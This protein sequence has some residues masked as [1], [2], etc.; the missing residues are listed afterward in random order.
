MKYFLK[1]NAISILYA[2]MIFIP[3]QLIVNVYRISRLI[4]WE[5]GTI[6]I[7]TGIILLIEVIAGTIILYFLT[8][9]WL[10]GRKAN[11]WTIILWIPYFVLFIYVFVTLFP[12]TY[13]GDDPNP[14][15]GLLIIGGLIVYPFYILILNFFSMTSDEKTIKTS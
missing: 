3:V 7:L 6:N 5:I 1:L 2:L 10:N 12:V 13:G 8:K 14:A 11:L 9:K 15:S 4:S